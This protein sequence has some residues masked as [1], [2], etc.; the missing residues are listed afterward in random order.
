MTS[1]TPM[2]TPSLPT[3][4]IPMRNRILLTPFLVAALAACGGGGG[5]DTPTAAAPEATQ[6]AAEATVASIVPGDTITWGTA[7]ERTLT[8]AVEGADGKPAANAGVRVFTLSRT[9]PQDGAP[10]EE[11]VPVSLLDS[12]VSD[13]AGQVTLPLRWPGHMNEVLVVATLDDTQG[14]RV[15]AL[16][17]GPQVLALALGR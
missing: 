14:R 12:A 2:N 11:P 15:V 4:P 3:G 7:T 17:A 10:L 13:A 9:S 5:G 16:D 6:A 1:V 8:F